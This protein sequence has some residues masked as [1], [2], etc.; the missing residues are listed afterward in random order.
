MRSLLL[1][2]LITASCRDV[3]RDRQ[4]PFSSNKPVE[5]SAPVD[6]EYVQVRSSFEKRSRE[7]LS[8]LDRRI[9]ALEQSSRESA[10]ETVLELRRDRNELAMRIDQ[11]SSQAKPTWDE[12]QARVQKLTRGGWR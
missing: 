6:H 10:H 8:K 3:D 9:A 5:R 1:L 12:F 11:I 7:R 2:L 4:A